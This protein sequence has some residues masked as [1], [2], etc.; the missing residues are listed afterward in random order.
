MSSQLMNVLVNM[1]I[2]GDG[3]ETNNPMIRDVDIARKLI[4]IGT[5]NTCS[6]KTVIA[7]QVTTTIVQ[8]ARSLSQDSTTQYIVTLKSGS[9]YRFRHSGGT[10]PVLRTRRTL[11]YNSL[12]EISVTKVGSVVRYTWNGIGNDPNFASNGAIVGDIFHVEAGGNFNPLNE[13]SFTIVAVTDDYIEVLNDNGVAES[14]IP[15]GASIDSAVPIDIFSASGVQIDDQARITGSVFNIENR[16][17]FTVTSVTAAYFEVS[18][19]NPGIP[20]GPITLSSASDVVFYPDIYKWLYI[21]SDQKLIVRLNGDTGNF[22]E[23]EPVELSGASPLSLFLFR[24]PVFRLD[25]V[26]NQLESANV[27]VILAE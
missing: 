6:K 25:L 19:G 1:L 3:S 11:A 21:E 5:G 13:G 2:Y 26:N 15:I 4:S 20:E 8:T 23:M 7:P 14:N 24:G 18:N 12:S 9:T 22:V 16:G 10:D 27:R 17:V